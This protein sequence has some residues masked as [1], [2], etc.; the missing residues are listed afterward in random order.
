MGLLFGLAAGVSSGA[1]SPSYNFEVRP[2]LASKC[3]ACH[4]MDAAK[5]KG[6]LRL[7]ERAAAVEK[8]AIVPGD[9]ENSSLWQ[10]LVTT[11]PDEV[12]P[13]PE[14]HQGV[15]ESERKV[16]EA[17]IKAGAPY[18][19]HWAYVPPQKPA[20]T[21][22]IA[23]PSAAIDRLVAD[24]LASKGLQPAPPAER[25]D[26]LRR[27][28]FALNGLPPK[29]EDV[30]SYLADAS[31]DAD[32]KVVDR[33]LQSP[34][35]GERVA[36]AWLD[37]ARY[38]DTYGRHEDADSPVWPYRDWVIRA[39]NDNLPYDQFLTYQMA[40][41]LLPQPSQDQRVATAFHRLASMSNESGSD[42]EQFRW[43]MIFDRVKTTSTAVLGLT[44]ECAR[45]HDHKYDPFTK[46]DYYGMAAFFDKIDEFGLFFRYVN[47]VPPPN[48][49]IYDGQKQSTHQ[50]LKAD[51]AK[52]EA[53][54]HEVKQSAGARF[55][56][57]LKAHRPPQPTS[58][59]WAELSTDS[60]RSASAFPQP[61]AYLSFDLFDLEKRNYLLDSHQQIDCEGLVSLRDGEGKLG[62]GIAFPSEQAKKI[63]FPKQIGDFS[64]WQ[65]FSISLWLQLDQ[66]LPKAV[67][68][69]HG[70]GGMDSGYRG[71]D[72]TFEDGHLTATLAYSHPGNSI[73]VQAEE[74][75]DFS[76][77]RHIGYTYDGSSRAEGVALYVDGRKLK[78]TV[79]RDHLTNEI[80]YLPEWGD[81]DNTQ[82]ADADIS[83][84]I[85]LVLGG[86]TLD[87]GL[88][89]AVMDEVR[90][91]DAELSP[92]EIAWLA[93]ETNGQ[94]EQSWTDWYLP[95]GGCRLP[96]RPG[97]R[98]TRAEGRI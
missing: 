40:G 41:D 48:A 22:G 98:Q 92:V 59:L 80:K 28:S 3:F 29:P 67:I 46:K 39:F 84:A 85:R 77:F 70:R 64:R 65:P 89:N 44:M 33:L 21:T 81:F 15:T 97:G 7:D 63:S 20:L 5:R 73:R 86:R 79:V 10:R 71:Y 12:M 26:W 55:A 82:V 18:E 95:R 56:A 13:P 8:K 34:H 6:K 19:A 23:D 11:D 16:L 90:V 31:P 38:A 9:L 24:T 54:L 94:T 57:W 53:K 4:G 2:I 96:Q 72:L 78:T 25:T 51:I 83:K 14:K 58:G 43:D 36:A 91:Y 45:C 52:A 30:K 17:W 61:A 42:P 35:Y 68:L 66:P 93:G 87:A 1:E 49:F 88:K 74:K 69:H 47:T 62:R 27:V 37:A 60:V 75:L 76:S 50:A 32:A